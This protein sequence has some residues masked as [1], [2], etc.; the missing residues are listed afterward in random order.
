MC[1]LP[2]VLLASP[3]IPE[4]TVKVKQSAFSQFPNICKT[5]QEVPHTTKQCGCEASGHSPPQAEGP[6]WIHSHCTPVRISQILYNIALLNVYTLQYRD[7]TV[8]LIHNM[9]Q[10]TWWAWRSLSTFSISCWTL[11]IQEKQDTF[12][13][14]FTTAE[15]W[16][17]AEWLCRDM[18]CCGG[19]LVPPHPHLM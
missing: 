12:L 17:W 18:W 15:G 7:I 8:K 14:L 13:H 5:R 3:K 6:H 1:W 2:Y 4:V 9:R 19:S 11:L 16:V 10:T